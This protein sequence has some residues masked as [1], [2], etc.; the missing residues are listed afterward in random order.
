MSNKDIY[1]HIEIT[2]FCLGDKEITREEALKLSEKTI[3]FTKEETR[4][5]FLENEEVATLG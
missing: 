1:D 4:Y 3:K 2:K 5:F